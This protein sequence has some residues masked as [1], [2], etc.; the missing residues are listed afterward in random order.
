MACLLLLVLAGCEQPVLP[1][2]PVVTNGAPGGRPVA[3]LGPDDAIRSAP[4]TTE[5]MSGRV[6]AG[7]IRQSIDATGRIA[8]QVEFNTGT[9][10]LRPD[11]DPL[12]E[13]VA[14]LLRND[15]GLR[16]SIDAHTGEVGHAAGNRTLSRQRAETVRAA[17]IVKGIDASRLQAQGFGADRTVAGSESESENEN[18]NGRAQDQ[19]VELVRLD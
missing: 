4:D 9:A 12:I 11:A 16:L 6:G 1:A 13:Q 18:D 7:Q 14:S 17:L 2:D 19:R 15:P 3:T 8:L 5:A 10:M